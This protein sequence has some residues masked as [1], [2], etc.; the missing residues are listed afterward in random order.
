MPKRKS[1][2]ESET[3]Q[4]AADTPKPAWPTKT[5]GSSEQPPKPEAQPQ[6]PPPA[7][8]A[9]QLP[10]PNAAAVPTAPAPAERKPGQTW[11]LVLGSYRFER[12]ANR[13]MESLH[14]SY[15][16][17]DVKKYSKSPRGPFYVVI[18]DT[19]TLADANE[20][21]RKVMSRG[22]TGRSYVGNF[23]R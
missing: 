21:R 2:S 4:P 7:A 14:A 22:I 10:P 1:I 15:P 9:V 19:M 11:R 13:R 20:L 3:R 12:D 23:P 16:D 17:L 18:G 8:P 5:L 6:T